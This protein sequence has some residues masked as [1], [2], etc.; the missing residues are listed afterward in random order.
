MDEKLNP[1]YLRSY[2]IQKRAFEEKKAYS[3]QKKKDLLESLILKRDKLTKQ[4]QTLQLQIGEQEH[5][6]FRSYESFL[7][8]IEEQKRSNAKKNLPSETSSN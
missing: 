8:Q 2:E 7:K 1:R 4:I 5:S 3:L 6:C